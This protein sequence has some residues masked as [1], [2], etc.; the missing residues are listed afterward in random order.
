MTPDWARRLM[1]LVAFETLLVA[2]ASASVPVASLQDGYRHAITDGKPL[3][4]C[5]GAKWSEAS[6][7]MV[8]ELAAETVA[9]ELDRWVV[10]ALDLDVHVADVEELGVTTAPALRIFTPSGQQVAA[11]D[12]RL[13]PEQLVAWLKKHYD[14][15]L[16]P[17]DDVL[18]GAG[19]PTIGDVLK[20]VKQFDDRSAAI[21][22][23]AIR[24]LLPYPGAAKTAV[25]KTFRERGL[26]SRLAAFDVLEAWHAPLAGFDPWRPE[27]FTPERM[28]TLEKWAEQ[29]VKAA[30]PT[31]DKLTAKEL[32]AARAQVERYLQADEVEADAAGYR[33]ARYGAALMPEVYARL[34]TAATDRDRHRLR[35][36][37]YRLV[38]DGALA[39]GWPGGIERLADRNPRQRQKA[40]DELAQ[41]A[42]ATEQPLLLELFADPDPLVR[43]ISLRG[44]QHIGGRQAND[45]LV[46]LLDDPDPN[47]RTAV[48]KRFEARPT[49]AMMPAIIKYLK[50]EKD[51]DLIGHG[52]RVLQAGKDAE[53]VRCLMALLKHETWQVRA[54]AAVAIGKVVGA[55]N[56]YTFRAHQAKVAEELTRLTVDVYV[57]LLGL[58]EDPE[59]FVVAKAVEGLAKADMAVAV[60]PLAKAAAKY[61]DLAPTI[62]K[63]LAN[64]NTMRP[65]AMPYFQKFLRHAEPR[66]R[67]AAVAAICS[68]SFNGC[69]DAMLAGLS[70]KDSRVRLAAATAA[71]EAMEQLRNAAVEEN[72]NAVRNAERLLRQSSP[73]TGGVGVLSSIMDLLGRAAK[74]AEQKDAKD[75]KPAVAKSTK[76]PETKKEKAADAKLANKKD[77]KAERANNQKP[78]AEE[79]WWD[80]WLRNCYAGKNRPKWT[81]KMVPLLEKMLRADEPTERATAAVLLV[82]LGKTSEA[83]PILEQT[84]R[85]DPKLLA[86]SVKALPWLLWDDRAK[87][88]QT[89]LSTDKSDER[90]ARLADGIGEIADPRAAELLWRLLAEPGIDGDDA[91]SMLWGMIQVY[92]GHR[93]FSYDVPPAIRRKIVDAATPRA[94]SGTDWQRRLALAI[95]A[96]AAKDDAAK[97]AAQLAD[98]SK[99]SEALRTEAFQVQLLV[100]PDADARRLALAALKSGQAKRHAIALRYLANGSSAL[101]RLPSGLQLFW[102][103]TQYWSSNSDGKPIVPEVPAGVKLEHVRPFLHDPDSETAASAGYLAVLLGDNE[104]MEPLLRQWRSDQSGSDTWVR[105]VYRAIAVADDPKYIPVLRDIFAKLQTYEYREFYWTIRIMSGEE[106]LKFRKEVRNAMKRPDSSE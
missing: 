35:V 13:P 70:D 96:I 33:L 4:V 102:A 40:A 18:L 39:L 48:L 63:M 87:L 54:E 101:R 34:K 82:P 56:S 28:A 95:L 59:P 98:D 7:K 83:M 97:L 38:A 103:T 85:A 93:G 80:Q 90:F 92:F 75:Q 36:L 2:F 32:T 68:M 29:D 86:V 76:K 60:E 19:E 9:K 67:A 94:L 61:P 74:A 17:A 62:L 45:A 41:R 24:R 5:V 64:G 78:A 88:F 57:A 49:A 58:L 10:V 100:K 81:P 25:V 51:A 99:L 42:T 84:L 65:K 20:L 47:V 53:A 43:E 31:R 14:A 50:R 55:D 71:I 73:M 91:S 69:E 46:K 52:I 89:L 23:A 37:R 44:L 26:S 8:R 77:G 104:G 3:L 27:T 79:F 1:F 21:R 11:S 30:K 72:S 66:V 16:A 6:R 22:E 106:I 105:P 12:R 15:A